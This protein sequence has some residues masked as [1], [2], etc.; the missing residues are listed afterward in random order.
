MRTRGF[1]GADH[2]RRIAEDGDATPG[3][4]SALPPGWVS[5]VV[6]ASSIRG[7]S[8]GGAVGYLLLMVGS[9]FLI[10]QPREARR[11]P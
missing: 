10:D 2:L 7:L 4:R 1:P 6:S 9:G 5:R 8:V 3:P 11:V